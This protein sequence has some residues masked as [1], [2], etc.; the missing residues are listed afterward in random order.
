MGEVWRQPQR[1][2]ALRI[3]AMVSIGAMRLAFEAWRAQPGERPLASF[4]DEEFALLQA[5]I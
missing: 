3:I 4:L 5:E 2:A 1:R